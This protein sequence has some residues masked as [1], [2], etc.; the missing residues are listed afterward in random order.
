MTPRVCTDTI[1][2][3]SDIDSSR[4]DALLPWQN[5]MTCLSPV[6]RASGRR[7]E[8]SVWEEASGLIADGG[9][10]DLGFQPMTASPLETRSLIDD[11]RIPAES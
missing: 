3:Q 5:Q 4:V 8:K 9:G 2:R 7:R 11:L 1:C 6:C 10:E